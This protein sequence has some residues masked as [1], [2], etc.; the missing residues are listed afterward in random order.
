MKNIL[1]FLL[2]VIF[3]LNISGQNEKKAADTG[4]HEIYLAKDD[5]SGKAGDASENFLTTDVPIY[6]IVKLDS[7]K[8]SVVK[9]NFVAVAV[10]G[11]KPETK[12][13]STIYK[14]SGLE[15][16]VNFTG[17]PDG[18]WVAGIYRIDVFVDGK[19]A[20]KKEFE[21]QKTASAPQKTTPAVNRFASPKSKI[22][23]SVREN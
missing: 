14:T 3:T 17:K 18:F 10:A 20:A 2:L 12:V 9:M 19:P 4:V 11:V 7:A 16:Q 23:R 5:G 1:L 13:L 6:C 8:P 21:I 22:S 15:D